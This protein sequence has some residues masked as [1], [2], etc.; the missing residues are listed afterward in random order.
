MSFI[1]SLTEHFLN[2]RW[3]IYTS[4][5][6]QLHVENQYTDAIPSESTHRLTMQYAWL[7]KESAVRLVPNLLVQR[8]SMALY[9]ICAADM[10]FLE[11]I[12][13]HIRAKRVESLP[14]KIVSSAGPPTRTSAFMLWMI[15][16]LKFSLFLQ[17]FF[18]PSFREEEY[19]GSCS[20]L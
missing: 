15:S 6:T 3:K 1:C 17:E 13:M 18:R 5:I 16:R 4:L 7:S 11:Y 12:P 9:N 19:L 10:V 14:E 2:K 20:V 8:I